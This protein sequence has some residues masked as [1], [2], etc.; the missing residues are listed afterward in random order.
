M[1]RGPEFFHAQRAIIAWTDTGS[2]LNDPDMTMIE[3]QVK[4]IHTSRMSMPTRIAFA[5][6]NGTWV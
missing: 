2:S 3:F 4:K 5:G 1:S 6:G